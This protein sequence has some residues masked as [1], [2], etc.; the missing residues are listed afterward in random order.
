MTGSILTWGDG[1]QIKVPQPGSA[2]CGSDKFD[3]R[4]ESGFDFLAGG[5]LRLP[6]GDPATSVVWPGHPDF[7]WQISDEVVY[8]SPRGIVALS[9]YNDTGL[10]PGNSTGG[11]S[12]LYVGEY[13]LCWCRQY[14]S[15]TAG[16]W[17]MLRMAFL[18]QT[19]ESFTPGSDYQQLAGSMHALDVDGKPM[20]CRSADDF[21]VHAGRLTVRGP[22]PRP[23]KT[24]T[25]GGNLTL[26]D[27]S[28]FGLLEQDSFRIQRECGMD[29]SDYSFLEAK[30]SGTRLDVVA[31]G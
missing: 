12:S 5:R 14:E 27:V 11:L 24:F 26:T 10:D 31:F 16:A 9:S 20:M 25:L 22:N 28:G 29:H 19:S 13:E 17:W 6:A 15:A 18:N 23:N 7:G 1:V 4:D 2:P 30:L 3:Y 21:Y 8:L